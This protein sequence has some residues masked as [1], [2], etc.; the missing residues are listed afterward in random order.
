VPPGIADNNPADNTASATVTLVP[1]SADLSIGISPASG[2]I[3]DNVSYTITVSNA[4]PGPADGVAVTDF[5]PAGVTLVSAVPSQGSVGTAGSTLTANLGT[6]GVGASAT[7]VVTFSTT[8]PG[9]YSTS[10]GVAA[11]TPD[12]VPADDTASQTFK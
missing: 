5:L 11:A 9:T 3:G 7:V 4:G 10:A 8:K 1:V 12:P 2:K 6:L